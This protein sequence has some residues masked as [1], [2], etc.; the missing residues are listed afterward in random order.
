MISIQERK[1]A[2]VTQLYQLKR[3]LHDLQRQDYREAQSR[4]CAD[5]SE[6]VSLTDLITMFNS[7][8]GKEK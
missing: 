1:L 3:E 6:Y 5:R 8:N 4:T 2:L 7:M